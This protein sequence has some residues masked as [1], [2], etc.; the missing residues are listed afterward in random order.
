MSE[1]RQANAIWLRRLSDVRAYEINC[2]TVWQ[3]EALLDGAKSLSY[4]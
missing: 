2:S 4:V 1:Q 3:L